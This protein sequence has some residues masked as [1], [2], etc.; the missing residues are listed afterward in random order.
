MS[1]Y[2]NQTYSV[3]DWEAGLP[4]PSAYV[5]FPREYKVTGI[6]FLG[7]FDQ[8]YLHREA[9]DLLNF[10]SDIGG[11]ASATY[12]GG[13]FLCYIFVTYNI[14]AILVSKLFFESSSEYK[15]KYETPTQNKSKYKSPLQQ[16][17][18]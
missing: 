14:E 5:D 17:Y 6:E 15:Q 7:S 9:Y 2:T 8:T 12:H 10:L 1:G 4:E 13:K 16:T 3:V 11:L 18:L